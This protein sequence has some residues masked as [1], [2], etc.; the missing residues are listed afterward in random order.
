MVLVWHA[1]KAAV[2]ADIK[3]IE[4]EMK[5]LLQKTTLLG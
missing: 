4:A 1:K 2:T 3:E 5:S